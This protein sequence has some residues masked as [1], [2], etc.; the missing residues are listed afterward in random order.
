MRGGINKTSP[1]P[2][3]SSLL[4][5]SSRHREGLLS[6]ARD[7]FFSYSPLSLGNSRT[8]KFSFD[9]SIARVLLALIKDGVRVFCEFPLFFAAFD[10][11]SRDGNAVGRQLLVLAHRCT[12]A[13]F[14]LPGMLAAG[15]SAAFYFLSS[16]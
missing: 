13:S 1:S 4:W 16:E 15:L 7:F 2:P 11:G 6:P 8:P 14:S 3:S 9:I 5:L 12:S 10:A